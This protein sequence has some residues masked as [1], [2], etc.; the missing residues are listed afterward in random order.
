MNEQMYGVAE[1]QSA[2]GQNVH[3]ASA[4]LKREKSR[5]KQ[6]DD[7][8]LVG[9]SEQLDMTSGR[10]KA[11]VAPYKDSCQTTERSSDT[12]HLPHSCDALSSSSHTSNSAGIHSSTSHSVTLTVH[13]PLQS[14]TATP[15]QVPKERKKIK[16]IKR[17]VQAPFPLGTHIASSDGDHLPTK[18]RPRALDL[19]VE[20]SSGT[21]GPD[22]GDIR[23]MLQELLNPQSVSLVTPIPTPNKV[24]PFTFPT[25]RVLA[26]MCW[27]NNYEMT[28]SASSLQSPQFC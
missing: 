3:P 5:K 27:H 15:S 10:K 20:D 4:N 6:Q 9:D 23:H 21:S 19:P 25:V 1:P 13:Q 26:I 24:K 7:L 16:K 28:Y 22:T 2:G 11:S 8:K 17:S 12:F 18:T 14:S